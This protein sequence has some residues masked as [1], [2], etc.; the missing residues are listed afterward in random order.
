ML[1]DANFLIWLIDAENGEITKSD[2]DFIRSLKINTEIL[3]VVNKADK[4]KIIN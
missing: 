4:K 2:L 3:F 1:S